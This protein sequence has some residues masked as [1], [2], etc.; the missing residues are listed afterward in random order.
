MRYA[1]GLYQYIVRWFEWQ[2]AK[3]WAR[4]YHPG[5]LHCF[6]KCKHKTTQEYY[7]AKILKAYRGGE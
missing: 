5:W 3:C 2:D 6:K 7:K 4:V 1:I